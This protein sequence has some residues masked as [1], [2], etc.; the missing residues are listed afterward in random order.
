MNVVILV[1]L[2]VGVVVLGCGHC[3]VG[4]VVVAVGAICLVG[5]VGSLFLACCIWLLFVV[6]RFHCGKGTFVP[7]L[8]TA[9]RI[10]L[11]R[12]VR[13]SLIEAGSWCI[14]VRVLVEFGSLGLKG[15][16]LLGALL[17]EGWPWRLEA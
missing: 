6:L 15:G 11:R 4:A 2:V 5:F 17:L 16:P 10:E 12:G 3:V 8:G 1:E 7:K 9:L 13:R 14:G